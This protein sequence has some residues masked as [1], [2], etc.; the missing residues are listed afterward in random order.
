MVVPLAESLGEAQ[1]FKKTSR[2][3]REGVFCR[4]Q[5][6]RDCQKSAEGSG[7][8]PKALGT[9]PCTV[10]ALHITVIRGIF[11]RAYLG[12]AASPATCISTDHL[13]RELKY[14]LYFRDENRVRR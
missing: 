9:G 1:A 7:L 5:C 10:T 6:Q 13:Q 4:L 14:I 12:Y 8:A 11:T 3:L 2:S